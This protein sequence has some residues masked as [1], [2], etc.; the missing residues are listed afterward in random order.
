MGT[1]IQKEDLYTELEGLFQI[2]KE[3]YEARD[4]ARWRQSISLGRIIRQALE[5][6][7]VSRQAITEKAATWGRTNGHGW[8]P[9][10]WNPLAFERVKD[11][12]LPLSPDQTAEVH[13]PPQAM[14]VQQA[15]PEGRPVFVDN[16]GR[17]QPWV[18]P[19]MRG[20]SD[21]PTWINHRK[22]NSGVA[23]CLL[24][25]LDTV[26]IVKDVKRRRDQGPRRDR[27]PAV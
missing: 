15:H 6:L 7:G 27:G 2:F 26:K 10:Q 22:R 11:R 12:A 3:R 14:P 25:L 13:P 21:Q 20:Q 23:D 9:F 18:G 5:N 17:N 16:H 4:P 19:S 1:N 8:N 24:E